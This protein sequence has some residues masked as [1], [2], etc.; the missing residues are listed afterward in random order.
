M[1]IVI[2]ERHIT[3][4]QE[5]ESAGRVGIEADRSLLR[6]AILNVLHNALKFSPNNSTLSVSFLRVESP[7]PRLLISFQDQGPGIAPGEH[8]RV[9]ERF[10]TSSA[11]ATASQSGTGLGLSVAK[12]VIDRVGGKIWF[13]EEVRQGAKC[14]IELRIFE[15]RP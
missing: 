11:H 7:T 10:F 12:L 13:D 9:F 6:V 5:G 14:V 1:E 15:P 4:I 3:V 2:D 8:R